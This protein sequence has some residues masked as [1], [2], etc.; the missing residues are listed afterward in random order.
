MLR[1]GANGRNIVGFLYVTS[2]CT[3]S[4]M[5]FVLVGVAVQS[6]R[7]VKLLATWKWTQQLPTMLRLFASGFRSNE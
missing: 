3:P 1:P 2:F 6:L 7:P 5:M 4:C